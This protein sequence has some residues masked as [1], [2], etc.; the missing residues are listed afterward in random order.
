[1]AFS[2][3][4]K[5]DATNTHKWICYVRGVNNEDLSYLIKKVEF[6]LHQSFDEPVKS[7][8]CLTQQ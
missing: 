6:I 4:K 7:I 2:M 5:I 3:G 8:A 1:M